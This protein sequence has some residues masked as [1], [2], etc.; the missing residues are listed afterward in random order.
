[1]CAHVADMQSLF[2]PILLY[3]KEHTV[4]ENIPSLP[5]RAQDSSTV[6]D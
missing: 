1:M 3:G 5:L 6:Q 4:F 2:Y